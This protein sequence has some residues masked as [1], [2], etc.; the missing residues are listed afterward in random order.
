MSDTVRI[1]LVVDDE[2][3]A[4]KQMIKYLHMV[5]E[6]TVFYEA[7][8][9]ADA[10]TFLEL[11]PIQVV[12]CDIN[13]P[14][15]DGLSLL[16]NARKRFP[17]I[18]FVI[19]TGREDQG[20]AINALKFGASDYLRKPLDMEEVTVALQRAMDRWSLNSKLDQYQQNLL[21][22]LLERTEKLE[23]VDAELKME[24]EE[25][26]RL[27]A[28]LYQAQRVETI[29]LLANGVAHDLNNLMYIMMG[30]IQLVIDEVEPGSTAQNNLATAL[31]AGRRAGQ[32]AK[33]ILAFS[34]PS[35][36]T[37]SRV[38]A[39]A[40]IRE[41]LLLIRASL[42]PNVRLH[43]E[44][45]DDS[46]HLEV[47]PIELH[48]I[49]LNLCANAIQA[50]TETGGTLHIRLRNIS[51]TEDAS[52]E[53][54][55]IVSDT[56]DGVPAHVT[57]R[58]FDPFFTTRQNGSGMGL[59][60]VKEIVDNLHGRILLDT[61]EG[62]GSTFSVYFPVAE[63]QAEQIP[64]SPETCHSQLQGSESILFVDSEDEIVTMCTQSLSRLGYTV[65]GLSDPHAAVELFQRSPASFDILIVDQALEHM[66]GVELT[67]ILQ[68]TRPD[69]P[70]L[71]C[72]GFNHMASSERSQATGI[73][74]YL[75]KPIETGRLAAAVRHALDQQTVAAPVEKKRI[76]IIDNDEE[77]RNMLRQMLES[78]GYNVM[79]AKNGRRGLYALQRMDPPIDLVLTDIFMPEQDG[80]DVVMEMKK[81]KKNVPVF[82]ISGHGLLGEGDYLAVA[83][84]LGAEQTFLKPVQLQQLLPAIE[85]ALYRCV[86]TNPAWHTLA[87]DPVL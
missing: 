51:K 85:N 81:T 59:A 58:I 54:V 29:G 38:N 55:L 25:N 6:H 39:A 36:S 11:Y 77:A 2:A 64:P 72:T 47:D 26:R 45:P 83:K 7:E 50:M 67:R 43:I 20:A 76:L 78:A 37:V 1:V 34:H 33:R 70:A 79:E 57:E 24:L 66:T 65:T 10:L 15:L 32:L 60:I 42:P 19:F 30:H 28:Q 4:R 62:K 52:N 13:M 61:I 8:N 71:L 31:C 18:E 53:L 86:V 44:I 87:Y 74:A 63:N 40:V 75:E 68:E 16:N 56:G 23:L 82:C 49:V 48:Q 22:L 5:F 3:T 9:G 17:K 80:L 14:K 35:S 46:R 69:L 12:L 73:Y 27:T 41:A 21:N 84:I